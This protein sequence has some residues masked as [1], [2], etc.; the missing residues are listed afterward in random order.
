MTGGKSRTN[1]IIALND[2]VVSYI[3]YVI[4]RIRAKRNRSDIN[5]KF[6]LL[7]LHGEA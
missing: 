1:P 7:H 5:E 3:A 6:P 4:R 2:G